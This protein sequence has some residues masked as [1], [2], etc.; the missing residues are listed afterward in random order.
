[1]SKADSLPGLAPKSLRNIHAMIHRAR[2]DC[3]SKERPHRQTG[4]SHYDAQA[5]GYVR[6]QFWSAEEDPEPFWPIVRRV[7]RRM[8]TEL[9]TAS[10][11][12]RYVD[13]RWDSSI[14]SRE[15]TVHEQQ[16]VS[17]GRARDQSRRK[18]ENAIKPS[19]S[20]AATVASLRE[21]AE[22]VR[23]RARV[24]RDPD[25]TR[26][27]TSSRFQDGR[28]SDPEHDQEG[29]DRLA[30]PRAI[31]IT[32]TTSLTFLFFGDRSMKAA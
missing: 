30:S 2:V 27:A 14:S 31:E 32:S 12:A 7:I 13:L 19:Q 5:G 18:T 4:G 15:I 29:F 6:V 23:T 24:L 20:N 16:G 1:M 10:A 22:G 26:G 21:M 8:F 28:P 17:R 3:T 25:T 11:A 9:T